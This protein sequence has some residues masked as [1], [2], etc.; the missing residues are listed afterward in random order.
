[1]DTTLMAGLS[2]LVLF[3][4]LFGANLFLDL[5]TEDFNV[6]LRSLFSTLF[7][8]S[9][10]CAAISFVVLLYSLSTIGG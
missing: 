8:F 1:M 4:S 3:I 9:V 5:S 7:W 6:F 10:I 2:L